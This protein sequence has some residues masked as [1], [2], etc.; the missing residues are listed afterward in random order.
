MS[1]DIFWKIHENLPRQGPGDAVSTARAFTAMKN[2][3]P[4]P[5]ILDV[6]CG[7]GAQT[8]DLARLT[9]GTIVAVDYYP[10]F[11]DHVRQQITRQDL[12]DRVSVQQGD[13]NNLSFAD[14][15]FDIIW[16]EG[17]IYIMG[18]DNGLVAWRRLLKPGG[19]LAVTEITWLRP[20]PPQELRDYWNSQYPAIRDA[21]SN[22]D[23]I[24]KAGY[25][26][27]EHFSLPESSWWD[28]YYRPIEAR[29]P[30]FRREYAGNE[31]ALQEIEAEQTEIDFYRKYSEYYGY[32]FYVMRLACQQRT[33][34]E[35]LPVVE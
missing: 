20:D 17:A 22:I 12:S 15:S 21:E 33:A 10:V 1:M 26:P 8:F 9:D 28:N 18:F 27:V 7:P 23:A 35:D 31:S 3:P 32:V 13:M 19:Y 25:L 11:V 5:R 2:L 24:K 30:S 14:Q 34:P 29:L 6:G 16:S 4:H